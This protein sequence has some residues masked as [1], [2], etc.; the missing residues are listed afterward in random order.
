MYNGR[1]GRT[2]VEALQHSRTL[3]RAACCT[4]K[5]IT[6]DNQAQQWVGNDSWGLVGRT[7]KKKDT[8]STGGDAP[9]FMKLPFFVPE[10][11]NQT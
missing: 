6:N 2:T 1:V 7:E 4:G 3:Y 11:R 5:T 8:T 10:P 9:N